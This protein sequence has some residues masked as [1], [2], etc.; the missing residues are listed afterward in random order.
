MLREERARGV[1]VRARRLDVAERRGDIR[2]ALQ[3]APLVDDEAHV[4]TRRPLEAG[5]EVL[6]RRVEVAKAQRDL[7]AQPVRTSL[8]M[9]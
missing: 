3:A 2:E 6:L 7:A 4:W 9:T 5:A 8:A 1:E